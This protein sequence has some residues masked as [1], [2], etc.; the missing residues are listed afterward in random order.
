MILALR[1]KVVGLYVTPADM[2]E[3]DLS[4]PLTYQDES[5]EGCLAKR[6]EEYSYE[7]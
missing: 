2:Q 3:A 7:P 5:G 1:L 4:L 6:K